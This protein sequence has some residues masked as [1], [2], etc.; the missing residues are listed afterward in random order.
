MLRA[1]VG[2]ALAVVAAASCAEPPPKPFVPRTAEERFG[3]ELARAACAGV[4]SCCGTRHLGAFDEATCQTLV[5]G[6]L[7]G[8]ARLR[9]ESG[10]G[11]LDAANAEACLAKVRRY[12]G[13]CVDPDH[14]AGVLDTEPCEAM[15]TGG[16]GA[17]KPCQASEECG[18]SSGA[19]RAI[20]GEQHTCELLKPAKSGEA[21]DGDCEP[22]DC[23]DPTKPKPHP[24]A[25]APPPVSHAF[26]A[27]CDARAELTCDADR[28]V[29]R[30]RAAIGETC[31]PKH[32]CATNA[33]CKD[34]HCAAKG[35]L[36]VSC[37]TA[38]DACNAE[39]TCDPG[40][41]TC[42]A[43]KQ[44]GESCSD[45]ADCATDNCAGRQ[46]RARTDATMLHLGRELR[47]F[48]SE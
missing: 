29:C 18:T 25:G 9:A 33:F 7:D 24:D 22:D 37:A 42:V 48:C 43:R 39:L 8:K 12:A 32:A 35:G 36:G 2:L 11:A 15:F 1:S 5:R 4:K 26:E 3:V 47:L 13:T 31:D 14:F 40:S 21:C 23:A 17:G 10:G 38:D 28:H 46:C 30:G 16:K 34:G 19:T 27:R 20:C 45:D 41:K 44:N 6:A